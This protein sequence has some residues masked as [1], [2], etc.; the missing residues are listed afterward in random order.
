MVRYI[1][2]ELSDKEKE[3]LFHL[4]EQNPEFSKELEDLKESSFSVSMLLSDLS[5]DA[6]KAFKEFES[7]TEKNVQKSSYRKK[8]GLFSIITGI[9][10]M[11]IIGFFVF[12]PEKP[13]KHIILASNKIEETRLPDGSR[14]TL[15]KSS[16]LV[17]SEDFNKRKGKRMV[18]FSGEGYFN[19]NTNPERPFVIQMDLIRI[20][21]LGTSFNVLQDSVE[22]FVKVTVDTGKVKIFN[23]STKAY[24]TV[25]EGEEGKFDYRS[26]EIIKYKKENINH[27]SWK[28]GILVFKDAPLDE[29]V[30]DLNDYYEVDFIIENESLKTCRLNTKIDNYKVSEVIE[31]LKL[32]FEI[33]VRKENDT[34][35]LSGE[36][37]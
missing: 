10:A 36:G 32:V 27:L 33:Q 5:F 35:Y 4:L 30:N 1:H 29:V 31:M 6:G 12:K 14:I 11:L 17:F 24:Q 20:E 26:R 7:L 3:E 19:V 13:E 18:E 28:T 8:I 34:Y 37:C 9:A 23:K 21:V 22:A 2:N 16:K 15:N 25:N